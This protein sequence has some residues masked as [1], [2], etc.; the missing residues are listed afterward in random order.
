[1]HSTSEF[2]WLLG[3]LVVGAGLTHLLMPAVRR[4]GVLWGLVDHPSWRRTQTEAVPCSGGISVYVAVLLASGGLALTVGLPFS[5]TALWALGLA[6]LG[7]LVLGVL[8]DRFG[9]HAEK[10]LLGQILVVSL[11][12]ASGLTLESITLPGLGALELGVLSGPLTLFWYLGFINSINLIDGLDGLAGGI[13]VVVLATILAVL[14]PNDPVG[15]LFCGAFL[16]SVMGFLRS[17]LSRHRIFL[18]DAGSMLLGLWVAGLGLGVATR[19]PSVPVLAV[20]AMAIPILDTATT[21]LRRHRRG[22][23]IFQADDEHLHHRLLRLGSTPRRAA[24]CLWIATLAAAS[25][26]TAISGVPSA[27]IITLG[28]MAAVAMELVVLLSPESAQPSR[29]SLSYLLGLKEGG[30][31]A[32]ER[33]GLAEVIEMPSYRDLRW[34]AKASAK[35]RSR[36]PAPAD[37]ESASAVGSSASMARAEAAGS[38]AEDGEGRGDHVVLAASKEPH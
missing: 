4:L 7:T 35:P 16:G 17:N 33:P 6:G 37:E 38:S 12:M 8:D 15:A 21:I 19:T 22:V 34:S 36:Q 24:S 25:L 3:V 13:V 26:G 23:S 11:P 2:G 32:T 31:P 27:G 29:K 18:G 14:V 28:A 5:G 9:L 20:V 1:M 10:K 30:E